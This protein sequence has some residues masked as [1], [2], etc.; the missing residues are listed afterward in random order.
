MAEGKAL[1]RLVAGLNGISGA[2]PGPAPFITDITLDSRAAAPGALFV[3][4]KGSALDGHAYVADACARGAV[5]VLSERPVETPP[6][7]VALVAPTAAAL[8][9]PL[10]RRFFEDPSSRLTIIGVTGTN[11]KTTSTYLMRSILA[12][13]GLP[14]A[15][16]GTVA[17]QI[18]DETIP[19]PNTTPDAIL[20]NRVLRRCVDAGISHVAMEVSS[21]A[22]KLGRVQGVHFATAVFTNLTQDHLDF[23]PDMEDYFRSKARLFTK[24]AGRGAVNVDDAY[25][26]RLKADWP[27]LLTFGAEGD[28]RADD[29]QLALGGTTFSL[30]Y[31]G[32]A[33]PISTRLVGRP[34]VANCLTAAAA[35]LTLG[36]DPAVIVS[37]LERAVAPPGRFE[38][39]ETGRDFVV[40]VD[41]A[42]TPD[43]LERLL[44]TGRELNPRRLLLVFGCGGDRDRK[45]R[46]VM[47]R[48]ASRL[49]DEV[50]VTSDNPRTE[51][52]EAII[53]EIVSA[54][55]K[56]HHRVSDRR[57]AITE[58][59]RTLESGDLLL[60]A[61]KGHEDYQIIGRTRHPFDDRVVAREALERTSD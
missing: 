9:A 52:A 58:A 40:A 22:L 17:Y 42:H 45:K 28:L 5:A 30:A 26:R 55:D 1:D 44:V 24:T 57:A 27:G 21:H 61:G 10:A 59:V 48:L 50:W 23:H 38:R 3:A 46:P 39:V 29:V 32:N 20:L 41:Y 11:G 33:W 43:A 47:G 34:N 35:A 49:A 7:V 53:D 13:A 12:A 31:G 6:G 56:P 51:D 60:I 14:A 25:G 15:V 19:A 37:G 16:I 2:V 4:L 36:L 8:L 18:G 54:M